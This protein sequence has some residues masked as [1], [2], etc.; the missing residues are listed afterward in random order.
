MPPSPMNHGKAMAQSCLGDSSNYASSSGLKRLK[1]FPLPVFPRD[2]PSTKPWNRGGATSYRGAQFRGQTSYRPSRPFRGR[3]RATATFSQ[4]T[5]SKPVRSPPAGTGMSLELSLKPTVSNHITGGTYQMR[6]TFV[7]LG[8][9]WPRPLTSGNA[10]AFRCNVSKW[11]TGLRERLKNQSDFETNT[12]HTP[13]LKRSRHEKG[14][15]N[16][17]I[18][19]LGG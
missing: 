6:R 17:M 18:L 2:T 7:F 5:P 3:G 1:Q 4:S 12:Q 16:C 14:I 19:K 13:P 8:S 9:R 11:R 10:H 15:Q